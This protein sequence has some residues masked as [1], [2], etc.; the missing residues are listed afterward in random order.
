LQ[1]RRTRAV[2]FDAGNT[3]FT[4]R[5][6][7]AQ[8]YAEV[9]RLHGLVVSAEELAE[10][11]RA[12]HQTLPRL[13]DGAFRY[14]EPWFRRF[15]ETVFQS[16]GHRSLP[17]GLVEEL[18]RRFRDAGTF[19]VFPDVS[20]TLV[21]LRARGLVLGVISNWTDDLPSLLQQTGLLPSF[22]FVLVSAVERVEK[23]D[24]EMFR[25]ALKR[26]G[27]VATDACVVGDRI[28]HDILPATE[29]GIGG[30]LLDRDG[31]HESAPA[32]IL[33]SLGEL[34]GCL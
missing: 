17:I 1:T 21:E 32:A 7:R 34:P 25:R 27:V 26:A 11:M 3:L 9:A 14:T 8:V 6:P 31:R 5:R 12:A 15:I 2:F 16:L 33:R 22:A 28:D 10:A 18:F 24:P 13:V 29:L 4:E 19:A 20:P 23:P 30:F